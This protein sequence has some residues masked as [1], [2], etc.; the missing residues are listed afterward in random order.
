MGIYSG[1]SWEWWKNNP[2]FGAGEPLPGPPEGARAPAAEPWA[3]APA[4]AAA[5]PRSRG[6]DENSLEGGKNGPFIVDFP[7][8]SGGSF[9]NKR[10]YMWLMMVNI[11]LSVNMYFCG[12]FN[13]I[14]DFS[15]S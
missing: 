7:M 12:P 4:P 10:V 11:R 13:D 8:K 5:A 6:P 3:P 15:G 9:H 14:I 2:S 1:F